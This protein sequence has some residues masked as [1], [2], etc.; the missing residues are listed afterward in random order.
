MVYVKDEYLKKAL[1]IDFE[2]REDERILKIKMKD[3]YEKSSRSDIDLILEN[4]Y[5]EKRLETIEIVKEPPERPMLI[6]EWPISITQELKVG[7]TRELKV[8]VKTEYGYGTDHEEI[9]KYYESKDVPKY[10]NIDL[11]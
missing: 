9:K 4:K 2:K 8:K 1:D 5:G 6:I 3:G 7:D 10:E 11:N